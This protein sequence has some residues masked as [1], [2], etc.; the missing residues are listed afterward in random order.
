MS[1]KIIVAL[2]HNQGHAA[3]IVAEEKKM[4][5]EFIQHKTAFLKPFFLCHLRPNSKMPI[6]NA[7]YS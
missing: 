5:P 3:A 2:E 1:D 6:F 4:S 7:L